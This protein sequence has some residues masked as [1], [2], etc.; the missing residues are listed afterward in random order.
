MN[1]YKVS[2]EIYNSVYEGSFEADFYQHARNQKEAKKQCLD[3][4]VERWLKVDVEKLAGKE[5]I[6]METYADEVFVW[7][8]WVCNRF[9][10]VKDDD[11]VFVPTNARRIQLED[12]GGLFDKHHPVNKLE[13]VRNEEPINE[14]GWGRSVL[15]DG[16]VEIDLN[17]DYY[18]MLSLHGCFYSTGSAEDPVALVKDDEVI[19][20]VMPL[21]K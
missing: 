13:F 4:V 17:Q 2:G 15:S 11:S 1:I 3:E 14:W 10:V 6:F 19:G 5:T 20:L 21:R 9:F 12:I 7:D 16:T 8:G 18:Q